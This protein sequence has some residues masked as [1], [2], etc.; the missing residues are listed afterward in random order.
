M[1]FVETKLGPNTYRIDC[2]ESQHARLKRLSSIVQGRA[3]ALEE[4]GAAAVSPAGEDPELRFLLLTALLVADR[5]AKTEDALAELRNLNPKTKDADSAAAP[6]NAQGEGES[7]KTN[8]AQGA[9]AVDAE[10]ETVGEVDGGARREPVIIADP[11]SVAARAAQT[12]PR[13]EPS[14]SAHDAQPEA[15][16][17]APEADALSQDEA[18]GLDPEIEAALAALFNSATDRLQAAA[19]A[20]ER[21]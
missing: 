20:L 9:K 14:F 4:S 2:A 10:V 18:G 13:V 6:E 3:A 19:E 15:D 1:A 8:N 17:T 7:G 11:A 12:A 5:L 16:Q 21:A